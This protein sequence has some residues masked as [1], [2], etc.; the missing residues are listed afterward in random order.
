[1]SAAEKDASKFDSETRDWILLSLVPGVGPSVHRS[2]IEHFGSASEVL[3]L[4]SGRLLRV[5]KVGPKLSSA[6]ATARQEINID[7][8]IEQCQKLGIQILTTSND[9]YPRLLREI[10]DPPTVLFCRGSLLPRD[11][12]AIAM[13]GTRHA[14][15]YGRKQAEHLSSSLARAGLTIVSGLA[16]GIDAVAHRAA[17]DAGGRTIAVLA[18]GLAEVYPPEHQD[19]AEAVVASGCFDQR[20]PTIV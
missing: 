15:A 6:I 4:P 10:H 14:T 18:S 13:V 1:M 8:E 20:K 19:L 16:R 3:D 9:D 11:R 17:I 7:A 5:D 2:L 12:L